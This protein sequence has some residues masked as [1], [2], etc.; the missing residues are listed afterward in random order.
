M[1]RCSGVRNHRWPGTSMGRRRRALL[2]EMAGPLARGLR[3]CRRSI[4][5]LLIALLL[6]PG[7][8]IVV[9][10][11]SEGSGG[12]PARPVATMLARGQ[13]TLD[14]AVA[15]VRAAFGGRVVAATPV[16]GGYR[17]RVLL[18]GGRV[19]TVFVDAASG[20]IRSGR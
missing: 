13:L 12:E 17:I 1:D 19:K 10:A 20:S 14:Q 9:H 2:P 7:G 6:G 18:D 4:V 5:G 8:T 11:Q 16:R 3:R 15:R